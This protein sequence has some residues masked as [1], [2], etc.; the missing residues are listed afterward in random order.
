MRTLALMCGLLFLAACAGASKQGVRYYVLDA[1][2]A[3]PPAAAAAAKHDA[4]LLI[5]PTTAVPF[6]D[7]RDIVFS[8]EAG[9]RGIYQF[10][11]W[12][13]PPARAFAQMLVV[14]LEQTGAFRGA[15]LATSGVAGSL[16]LRTHLVEIYHDAATPPG[17][18]RATLVAELSDPAKGV[19]LARRSF[20]AAAPAGAY[21][22]AGA[23]QGLREAVATL[24]D[25]VA[26]WAGGAAA[27][28]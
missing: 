15:F 22:A 5:A 21:D 19:L 10:S 3:P 26:T 27:S 9:T 23:V 13:E 6:Y 28:R 12:T 11:R 4:L 14:R 16:L 1:P 17:V 7:T 2:A 24:V 18:A 20:T 8:R 25:E